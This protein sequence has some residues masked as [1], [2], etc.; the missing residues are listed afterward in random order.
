M[1]QGIGVAVTAAVLRRRR[2]S[3][4]DATVVGKDQ[5]SDKDYL[6]HG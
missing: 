2:N 3:K 4:G 6:L 1:L 5:R